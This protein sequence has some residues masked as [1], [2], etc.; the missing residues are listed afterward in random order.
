[1]KKNGFTLVE[2]AAVIVI[3]GLLMA[4]AVPSA[5]RISKSVKEKAYETKISLIK[6]AAKNYGQSNILN[7]QNG[8]LGNGDYGYCKFNS[9][10]TSVTYEQSKTIK[11]PSG[12]NYNCIEK[13]VNDLVTS[14]NIKYDDEKNVINPKTNTVLND[15]KVYIYYKNSRVYAF[16]LDNTKNGCNR[17]S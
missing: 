8:S 17:L 14:G 6:E 2:I 7:V 12:T 15:C 16:F 1:M 10:F 4:I 3:L 5:L 9:A 11:V 13:T